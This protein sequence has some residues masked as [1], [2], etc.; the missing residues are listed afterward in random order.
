MFSDVAPPTFCMP[1]KACSR[2]ETSDDTLQSSQLMDMNVDIIDIGSGTG[3]CGSL[4]RQKMPNAH[5]SG[6]IEN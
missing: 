3:L 5:I 2:E 4:I 1:W 6:E